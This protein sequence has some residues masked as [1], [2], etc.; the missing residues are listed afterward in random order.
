MV[1]RSALAVLMLHH[2][3]RLEDAAIDLRLFDDLARHGHRRIGPQKFL[4]CRGDEVGIGSKASAV[5]GTHREV[6]EARTDRAPRGV[7]ARVQQ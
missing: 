5:V 3:T 6:P 7:N 1:R 2:L 4:D